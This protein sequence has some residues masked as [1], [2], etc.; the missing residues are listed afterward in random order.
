MVRFSHL[1]RVIE[2]LATLGAPGATANAE[3]E[4]ASIQTAQLEV[5]AL[6]ARIAHPQVQLGAVRRAA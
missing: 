5:D 1:H 2:S 6:V 4:L 3:S